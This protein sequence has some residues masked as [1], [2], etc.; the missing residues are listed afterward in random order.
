MSDRT[1]YILN[2]VAVLGTGLVAGVF[3]AFSSFIMPAF[4]RLPSATGMAAMQMINVTVINP[5]FMLILFGT[6]LMSLALAF[7]TWKTGGANSTLL[8]L[9]AALYVFGT[10]GITLAFN[11]PLNENL[12]AINAAK[13][14]S[15][16][17]WIEYLQNWTFWNTMRG[18]SASASCAAFVGA[19]SH[20]I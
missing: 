15:D 6:A 20:W 16:K 10:I 3:L 12:A 18:V 4:G 2:F 7:A 13:P 19:I 9:A 1:I 17:L 11:I 5:L 14:E 8:L